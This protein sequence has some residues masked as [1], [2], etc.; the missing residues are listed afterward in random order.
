[1]LAFNNATAALARSFNDVLKKWHGILNCS[2]LTWSVLF[3]SGVVESADNIRVIQV[4]LRYL[5]GGATNRFF[6]VNERI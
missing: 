2:I 5:L 1:M 6:V 3:G 4:S